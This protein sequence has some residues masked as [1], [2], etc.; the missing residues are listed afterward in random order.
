MSARESTLT[1]S[2]IGPILH[3][4]WFA[5]TRANPPQV[6]YGYLYRCRAIRLQNRHATAHVGKRLVATRHD[7][8]QRVRD[9]INGLRKVSERQIDA[10]CALSITISA[11]SLP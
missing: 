4:P 1:P 3:P 6:T 5:Q 2:G 7:E 9:Q 11:P 8:A 10:L